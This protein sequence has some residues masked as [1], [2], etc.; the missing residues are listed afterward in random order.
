MGSYVQYM[1]Y[2]PVENSDGKRD[3][4]E[5]RS[6]IPIEVLNPTTGLVNTEGWTRFPNKIMYNPSMSKSYVPFLKRQKLW[7]YFYIISEGHLITM[8]HTDIGLIKAAYV[9]VRDIKNYKNEIIQ[10]RV[11]DLFSKYINIFPDINGFGLESSVNH[12]NL[13]M[14]FFARSGGDLKADIKINANSNQGSLSGSFEADFSNVEGIVG[15]H[16]PPKD[17]YKYFLN[18]KVP[19]IRFVGEL[20]LNSK[21]IV[22]WTKASPCLGLYDGR[23]GLSP[24]INSWIWASSCFKVNGNNVAFNIGYSRDNPDSKYDSIFVDGKLYKL[25]PMIFTQKS[26]NSYAWIKSE[27]IKTHPRNSIELSFKRAHSHKLS[28]NYLITA[29]D[30][31][32]NFGTYSGRIQTEDGHD[33]TFENVFGFFW[34]FSCQMV[35]TSSKS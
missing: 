29:V 32:S 12:D 20:K 16:S 13:N 6:D 18:I 9:N 7:N 31:K 25:D 35:I 4:V 26:E 28:A 8:A 3:F 34:R 14:T 1:P 30:F 2:L 15:A 10:T 21:T 5:L 24:Y 17:Q 27:G 22:V 19:L 33:I 23:R 11:E